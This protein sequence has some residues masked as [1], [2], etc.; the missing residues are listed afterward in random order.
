[1]GESMA[2]MIR[3]RDYPL[4]RIWNST[5]AEHA[6][7]IEDYP[8]EESLQSKLDDVF[9]RDKYLANLKESGKRRLEE[10]IG[11]MYRKIT[12]EQRLEPLLVMKERGLLSSDEFHQQAEEMGLSAGQADYRYKKWSG[13]ET[14]IYA[15]KEKGLLR[16]GEWSQLLRTK[17]LTRGQGYYRYRK[18][19]SDRGVRPFPRQKRK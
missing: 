2:R 8:T 19:L 11:E 5:R 9:R 7:R 17:R 6:I 16:H 10:Y 3:G 15:M 1:M 13:T 4:E 18:Y 14:S 12:P